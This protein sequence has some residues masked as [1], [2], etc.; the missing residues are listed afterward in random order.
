MTAR[1]RKLDLHE[2]D[3][4]P[5]IQ[6]RIRASDAFYEAD[7]QIGMYPFRFQI[8]LRQDDM[9]RICQGLQTKLGGLGAAYQNGTD[10][11]K[12][13]S[14]L[15]ALAEEG[16]GALRKIF[17]PA[18]VLQK[19]QE[20]LL[21]PDRFIMQI[22]SEDF[23]IPWDAL[24]CRGL[25]QPC[26]FDY[27][28]GFRHIVSRMIVVSKDAH[29]LPPGHRIRT[30]VPVLGLLTN[31]ELDALIK[32]EL[33][34][35][36]KRKQDHQ[37][38]FHHLDKELDPKD[39]RDIQHLRRF[40]NRRHDILHFACHADY[41]EDGPH[42]VI[43]RKFKVNL[44]QL[45]AYECHVQGNPVVFLNA[46]RTSDME[47]T[48]FCGLARHFLGSGARA[49]IATECE[50]P[51]SFAAD[52]SKEVYRRFLRNEALGE[53]VFAARHYFNSK[54]KNPLGLLYTLYGPPNVRI[55]RSEK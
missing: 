6:L 14:A 2:A 19:I 41:A 43:T 38:V 5:Y 33:P 28:L 55:E 44:N 32:V 3:Y 51:D 40:L 18:R 42:F 50:V 4:S 37:I 23:S 36:E 16:Y 27:F 15:R 10:I 13:Q 21:L 54:F 9:S 26:S 45:V 22:T 8:Q 31:K 53:C 49:L 52:F 46:C 24:Y 11:P 7:C 25:N 39:A 35:F 34:F 48:Y 30:N 1:V 29:D 20:A 12:Q 47:P 17:A